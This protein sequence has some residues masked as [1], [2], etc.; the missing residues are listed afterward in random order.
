[1]VLSTLT[2]HPEAAFYDYCIEIILI[3]TER[4]LASPV[5]VEFDWPVAANTTVTYGLVTN[6]SPPLHEDTQLRLAH[7]AALQTC[8]T[9]SR[10]HLFPYLF[11]S[12]VH[13]HADVALI[14]A[15][16]VDFQGISCFFS[17]HIS[18]QRSN[19]PPVSYIYLFPP[20]PIKT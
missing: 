3:F 6:Q 7:A 19:S 18:H 17:N 2:W 15:D 1:M 12:H 10:I 8:T 14:T 16:T 5:F 4:K 11:I 20:R 9:D 13:L